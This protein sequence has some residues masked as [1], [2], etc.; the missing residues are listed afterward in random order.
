MRRFASPALIPLALAAALF[1]PAASALD[2]TW[3]GTS[4]KWTDVAR[5]S[6]GAVPGASDLAVISAGTVTLS[7]TSGI[8]VG[9]LALSGGRLEGGTLTL[10]GNAALRSD[11]TGGTVDAGLVV[12]PG[13]LLRLSGAPTLGGTL[14]VEGNAQ[15]WNTNPV[16]RTFRG[17]GEVRI[18][19]AGRFDLHGLTV[20]A[21]AHPRFTVDEGGVL[22]SESARVTFTGLLTNAG[23][24]STSGGGPAA[25]NACLKFRGGGILSGTLLAR[26]SL[27]V[28]FEAGTYVLRDGAR[29]TYGG[30]VFNDSTQQTALRGATWDVQGAVF[31]SGVHFDRGTVSGPG[32]LTLDRTQWSGALLSG[33]G[34]TRMLAGNLAYG[35]FRL[36]RR[37]TVEDQGAFTWLWGNQPPTAS[38]PAAFSVRSGGTLAFASETGGVMDVP[39]TVDIGGRVETYGTGLISIPRFTSNPGTVAVFGTG[40]LRPASTFANTGR[41]EGG[42]ALDVRTVAHTN[43]AAFEPF[44]LGGSFGSPVEYPD[45]LTVRGDYT[46]TALEL[47]LNAT[48]YRYSSSEIVA[49]YDQLVVTGTGRL[50]GVLALRALR[51]VPLP[52]DTLTI[53]TCGAG[54]TG[55]FATVLKPAGFVVDVVYRADRV[56][57]VNRYTPPLADCTWDNSVGP[58]NE[59]QRWDCRRVPGPLDRAIIRQGLAQVTAGVSVGALTLSGNGQIGGADTLTLLGPSTWSGGFMNQGGVTVVGPDATLTLPGEGSGGVVWVGRRVEVK[60]TV[61]WTGGAMNAGLAG[62]GFGPFVVRDGG[63]FMSRVSTKPEVPF[64]VEA[65]GLFTHDAAGATLRMAGLR[66]AGT[67]RVQKGT[68]VILAANDQL[69]LAQRGL[70]ETSEGAHLQ[71][72]TATRLLPGVAFAGEGLVTFIQGNLQLETDVTIPHFRYQDGNLSGAGSLTVGKTMLWVGGITRPGGSLIVPAG[73]TLNVLSNPGGTFLGRALDISGTA[74]WESAGGSWNPGLGGDGNGPIAVRSGGTFTIAG[75]TAGHRLDVPVLVEAGGLLRRDG[76]DTAVLNS[77]LTNDGTVRLVSGGIRLVGG[78]VNRGRVEGTGTLDV[79]GIAWTNTGTFA[80]G[81]SPGRLTVRG[82]YTNRILELEV[83]GTTPGVDY[84]QL[85][86]T[87]TAVFADTLRVL[88]ADGYRP[89]AGARFAFVS[90]GT[91]QGQF[92]AVE[93]DGRIGGTLAYGPTGVTFDLTTVVG[94]DAQATRPGASALGLPTPNPSRGEGTLAYDIAAPARVRLVVYDLLGRAVAVLADADRAPGRYAVRVDGAALPPGLYVVRMTAGA[95]TFTRRLTVV[96]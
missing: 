83:G 84:D 50:G 13:A 93:T 67:V 7:A 24:V 75:A 35:G 25:I 39:F 31:V 92:R 46:N 26:R 32:T 54:C 41:V 19:N 66:N 30:S 21:E 56:L 53:V 91:V 70:F 37:V 36:L 42:G 73:A 48:S 88:L 76:P 14:R 28:Q 43:T 12:A 79:D 44:A 27:P 33:S 58:W 18:P 77:M 5:W 10:V 2:C 69:P 40:G 62:N 51:N 63:S 74:R 22:N 87:G 34:D 61:L 89:A 20:E 94:A 86:V 49:P 96:R 1:V 38:G 45:T 6:C 59:A 16:Q 90:A 55:T 85:V 9:R 23:T 52:A 71:I 65:G 57:V 3:N 11:W 72:E 78:F 29:I 4:G 8:S 15:W 80:P 81:A 68:V 17:A 64:V 82:N 95:D 47:D 60:G